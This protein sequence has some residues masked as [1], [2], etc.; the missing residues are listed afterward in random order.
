MGLDTIV[1]AIQYVEGR[2]LVTEEELAEDSQSSVRM[3]ERDQSPSPPSPSPLCL[4]TSV[5]RD[6]AI[7]TA[8]YTGQFVALSEALLASRD[9]L[10]YNRAY[11]APVSFRVDAI[12]GM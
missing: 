1:A 8:M 9:N 6:A 7:H 5:K 3:C 12:C 11:P 4:V 10:S 2:R